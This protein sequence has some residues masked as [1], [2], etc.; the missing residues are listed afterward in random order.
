MVVVGFADPIA[1][2]PVAISG[3]GR[4]RSALAPLAEADACAQS[5]GASPWDFAVGME[6]L[7][8]GGL[9]T[10]DLRWLVRKGYLEHAYEV[11]RPHD[12]ARRFRSC[13]NLAF[14][15]RTCF[16]LTEA[17]RQLLG[18]DGPPPPDGPRPADHRAKLAE[19]P[20]PPRQRS[21]MGSASPYPPHGRP[22][23]EA[24]QVALAEPGGH[25]VGLRGAGMA[26]RDRRS[27]AAA[28][29]ARRPPPAT[30][31]DPES[32]RKPADAASLFPRRRAQPAHS[33]AVAA[34]SPGPARLRD[35]AACVRRRDSLPQ[36]CSR[37]Q[38]ALPLRS[39]VA[40]AVVPPP[41]QALP[42]R[43]APP[44]RWRGKD[45]ETLPSSPRTAEGGCSTRLFVAQGLDRVQPRGLP[46]RVEAENHPHA[47]RNQHRHQDRREWR[48]ACSSL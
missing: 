28:S 38:S 27:V 15:E 9:T 16:V 7:L 23:G 13:P 11:T 34:R 29:R 44:L 1:F 26:G 6:M 4:V 12:V 47:D 31:H 24:I 32:Q 45:R 2:D 30:E 43:N 25:S 39:H 40:A 48:L 35:V 3:S 18:A 37:R 19:P 41:Q 21:V 36:T 10:S 22:R 8:A 42:L 17:G 5:T 33:L 46:G 14:A 20:S